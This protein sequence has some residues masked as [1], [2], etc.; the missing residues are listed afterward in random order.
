MD[1]PDCSGRP[2]VDQT[3]AALMEQ[4]A[5]ENPAWGLSESRVN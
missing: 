4:M 3:I 1:L 2:P 5:R